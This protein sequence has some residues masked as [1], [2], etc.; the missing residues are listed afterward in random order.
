MIDRLY[1]DSTLTAFYN[2]Y[3]TYVGGGRGAEGKGTKQI[4]VQKLSGWR[5]SNVVIS[6]C[7]D[8]LSLIHIQSDKTNYLSTTPAIIYI[9]TR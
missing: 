8:R 7:Y 5:G 2:M 9:H 6:S 3:V 1:E 4:M